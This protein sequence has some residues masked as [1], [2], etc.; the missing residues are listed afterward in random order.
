MEGL[1]QIKDWSVVET[2]YTPIIISQSSSTGYK[3]TYSV[4]STSDD[5]A[6]K[7]ALLV[8]VGMRYKSYCSNVS[9]TFIVDP[10]PV[11]FFVVL[12]LIGAK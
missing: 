12:N 11:R 1:S 2:A 7:G 9:R 5:I 3:L 6:H 8:S 10:T 4:E